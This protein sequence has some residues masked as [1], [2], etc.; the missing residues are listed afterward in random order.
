MQVVRLIVRKLSVLSKVTLRQA[1]KF[2]I[3]A[4][5]LLYSIGP[6]L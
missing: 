5:V 3:L 4:V 1:L 6:L 2:G